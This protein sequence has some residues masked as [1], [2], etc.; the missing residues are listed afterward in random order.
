[1]SCRTEKKRVCLRS[2]R[3]VLHI[4]GNCIC[5]LVLEGEGDVVLHSI[6]CL[7]CFLYFSISLFKK[8]LMLRRD[9][10]DKISGTIFISHIILGLNEML[11]KCCA[12]LTV[13]ILMELEHSLRFRTISQ[14]FVSKC[15]GKH[16]H[17]VFR[18]LA[19][20]LAEEFRSVEGKLGN[21]VDE[22]CS[23]SI[24]CKFLSCLEGIKSAEK[25][26]EHTRSRT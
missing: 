6:L 24:I 9:G 19:C 14:T 17:P 13:C 7:I 8:M 12:Y 25:V 26:L 11:G 10:H 18:A 22:L 3:L 16:F 21:P 15:L 1:M 20:L 2:E 23:R 4:H 5:R